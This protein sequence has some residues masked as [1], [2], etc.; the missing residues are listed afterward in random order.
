MKT[1][2]DKHIKSQANKVVAGVTVFLVIY[3][4]S[5]ILSGMMCYYVYPYWRNA[6]SGCT[7]LGTIFITILFWTVPTLFTLNLL[8]FLFNT[9]KDERHDR[10]EIKEADSPRLFAIIKQLVRQEGCSMPKKVFISPDVNACVFYNTSFWNILI[11]VSKNLQVGAGLLAMTNVDELRGILAHELGH[12][13]QNS[14]KVGAALSVNNRIITNLAYGN[15]PW[16]KFVTH[17]IFIGGIN[18]FAFIICW[19]LFGITLGIKKILQLLC[20]Q[21]NKAYYELSRQME[22]DADSAAAKAVGSN[23]FASVLRKIEYTSKSFEYVQYMVAKLA[24]GGK[25]VKDIFIYHAIVSELM[26]AKDNIDI[27][28]DNLLTADIGEEDAHSKLNIKDVWDDHP[29]LDDR[30]QNLPADNDK[31]FSKE[32]SFSVIPAKV[33]QALTFRIYEL[34]ETDTQKLYF[35]NDETLKKWSALYLD[36]CII[37]TGFSEFVNHDIGPFNLNPD[38]F[39]NVDNPFTN[40]NR[41]L[42]K[43]FAIASSDLDQLRAAENGDIDAA[44]IVYNGET[45]SKIALE[46]LVERQINHFNSL[47]ERVNRIDYDV[48]QYTYHS[49]AGNKT[50]QET[51]LQVYGDLFALDDLIKNK[52]DEINKSLEINNTPNAKDAEISEDAIKVTIKAVISEVCNRLDRMVSKETSD[53]YMDVADNYEQY[54]IPQML[55]AASELFDIASQAAYDAKIRLG[56]L[57]EQAAADTPAEERI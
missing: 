2:S 57:Y 50:A 49:F 25:S 54:S 44:E 33:R 40:E 52:T 16:D 9:T 21:T 8:I 26:A 37:P 20:R 31:P 39:I 27:T 38:E 51:V 34:M 5:L 24:E 10:M 46:Q 41:R 53:D 18:I 29:A 14:M 1:E 22:Y 35:E 42:L 28:T 12:F 56:K 17:I 3:I 13:S 23:V 7:T 19:S 47:V 32:S 15:G 6:I 43:E 30:I 11:P 36:N 48:L 4:M 55:N 45:Y